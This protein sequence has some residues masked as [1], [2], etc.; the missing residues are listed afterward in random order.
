VGEFKW[1]M[2]AYVTV[3]CGNDGPEHPVVTVSAQTIGAVHLTDAIKFDKL[4]IDAAG[5]HLADGKY[6]FSVGRCS[7]RER[8]RETLPRV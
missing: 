6:A 4:M 3:Y 7:L 2:V 1:E 8:D 5:Y